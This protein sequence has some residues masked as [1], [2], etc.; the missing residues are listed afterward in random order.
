MKRT[1]GARRQ[2]QGT[3]L[4]V[5]LALVFGA[6]QRLARPPVVGHLVIVPLREDRNL[7]VERAHICVEQ[8]VFVVAAKLGKR[9]RGF[10]LVLGHEVFPNLAVR[11]FLLGEDW[12]VGVDIIAAVDEEIR[13]VAQHCGV[14]AHAAARLV[15]APALSG[16]VA[17]PHERDRAPGRKWPVIGSPAMVGEARSWKRMR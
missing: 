13:P 1:G 14:G 16:G 10:S 17:R 8:I 5:L 11:H 4:G 6:R 9:L 3:F 7:S 15:D 12:T 2:H